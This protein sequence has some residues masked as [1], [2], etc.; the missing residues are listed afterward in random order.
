MSKKWNQFRQARMRDSQPDVPKLIEIGRR[1][2]ERYCVVVH[3]EPVCL[4]DPATR[5][6]VGAFPSVTE[7]QFRSHV[8]HVP[9]ML[10]WVGHDPWFIELDG[11]IHSVNDRVARRDADRNA[12][13]EGAG[14]RHAILNER[15]ILEEAGVMSQRAARPDE[16]WPHVVRIM[17]R[18]GAQL[19]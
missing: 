3:R 12:T 7:E 11:W 17:E 5:G 6:F 19:R 2:A 15:Q 8:V 13:Y 9:D 14:I 1:L 10:V 16:V 18:A 4:F